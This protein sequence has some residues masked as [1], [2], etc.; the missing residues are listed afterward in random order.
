MSYPEPF[1]ANSRL[2]PVPMAPRKERMP[3][4]TVPLRAARSREGGRI[5]ASRTG[6][7]PA[8]GRAVPAGKTAAA[9]EAG[10]S[11]TVKLRVRKRAGSGFIEDALCESCGA[12]LGR[13]GGEVQHRASRGSGGS[14]DAVIG[15]CANAVLLCGRGAAPVRSGCHGRCEDRERDMRDDAA[16]FWIRHGTTAEFDPRH[17]AI[18]LH[19]RDSGITVW[20]A[21][22]GRGPDGTGYLLDPPEEVAA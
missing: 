19:G 22:D 20:L 9:G 5:T 11:R 6:E 10:F 16:G 1:L 15:G 13:Y 18:M 14:T 3:R 2:K 12:W 17:V 8:A 21:E 7:S 4:G